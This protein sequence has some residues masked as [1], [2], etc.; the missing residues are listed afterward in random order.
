[1]LRGAIICPDRELG[2]RLVTAILDSHQVGIVRRMEAYPNAIELGRFIRAAAPEV[3]FLSIES[4]QTALET[5]KQIE[6]LWRARGALTTKQLEALKSV[7]NGAGRG[8]FAAADSQYLEEIASLRCLGGALPLHPR[9]AE[10]LAC[11][12]GLNSARR[13]LGR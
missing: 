8:L 2:D 10:P 13:L 11:A 7:F 9:I 3:I 5:A 1:M 12:L 4:R 6:A